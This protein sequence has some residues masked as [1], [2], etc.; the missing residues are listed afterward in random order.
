MN[1]NQFCYLMPL[2]LGFLVSCSSDLSEPLESDF[3]EKIVEKSQSSTRTLD[4]AI[5]IANDARSM[6]DDNS[7]SRSF[8][9]REVNLN[10][11]S[12]V[13]SAISRS[14]SHTLIY[15]INYKDEAGFAVVSAKKTKDSP[16]LAVTESGRYTTI[17]ECDNPGFAMFMDMAVNYVAESPVNPSKTINPGDFVIQETRREVEVRGDTVLPR[18][19]MKWGQEGIYGQFCPNGVA[20]CS[21]TAAA[22][23]M[24]YFEYPTKLSLSYINGGRE[25]I[26]D[27]NN[28]KRHISGSY[29]FCCAPN[30]PH[31][32][33]AKL[34]REL[35]KRSNS[36]YNTDPNTTSTKMSATRAT[37]KGLGY[38]VSSIDNYSQHCFRGVGG[39]IIIV[40]GTRKYIEDDKEKSVGHMWVV[41]GDKYKWTHV[42]EYVR[43]IDKPDWK[44]LSDC[45][46]EEM[47]N[48]FNWGFDGINDGYFYDGVFAWNSNV[49]YKYNVKYFSIKR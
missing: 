11:I 10:D 20:G 4:E 27:W 1:S 17:E 8:V 15:V 28:I 38:T 48:Y 39:G 46:N 36:T 37:L 19:K 6:F 24:S 21:N 9:S 45:V 40:G 43:D 35:G 32:V 44:I 47:Y 16:L 29:N 22:M 7:S 49:N 30:A 25:L 31:S 41:S 42:V 18:V 13:T 34:M 23:A 5:K 26:L 33:I 12:Y 2:F 14:E 3:N